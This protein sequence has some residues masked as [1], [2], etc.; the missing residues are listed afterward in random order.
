MVRIVFFLKSI[1]KMLAGIAVVYVEEWI[2]L[3]CGLALK[4]FAPTRRDWKKKLFL[5][6]PTLWIVKFPCTS[7]L[8][9]LSSKRE[10]NRVI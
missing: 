4:I 1:P 2:I 7:L 3:I 6:V 10:V 9:K 5:P 8:G